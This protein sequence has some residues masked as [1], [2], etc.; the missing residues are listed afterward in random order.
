MNENLKPSDAVDLLKASLPELDTSPTPNFTTNLVL[1]AIFG[2]RLK[3]LER[4]LDNLG[5]CLD[6]LSS[7]PLS[8]LSKRY[9]RNVIRNLAATLAIL[10]G[11][12][13]SGVIQLLPKEVQPIALR[14]FRHSI[15]KH[16]VLDAY[17]V[18]YG[19][20]AYGIMFVARIVIG[21]IS[22]IAAP[23]LTA[24][25]LHAILPLQSFNFIYYFLTYALAFLGIWGPIRLA[26]K[27]R[28]I[29]LNGRVPSG[30]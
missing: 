28:I 16:C 2:P 4:V 29:D 10:R 7:N 17:T 12:T 23:F 5:S 25:W 22:S 19:L 21:I 11:A 18:I 13:L 26:D 24:L 1:N 20:S 8:T 3:L 14:T 27:T 6:K 9:W 15:N 30:L